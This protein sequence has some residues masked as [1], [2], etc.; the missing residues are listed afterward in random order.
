MGLSSQTTFINQEM[1]MQSELSGGIAYN[2]ARPRAEAFTSDGL[3]HG[4]HSQGETHN[5]SKSHD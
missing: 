4:G 5:G 2:Y 1:I 3:R